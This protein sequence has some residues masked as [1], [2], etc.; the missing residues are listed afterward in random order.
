MIIGG[1][2][3]GLN[4]AETLRQSGYTGQIT[5]I[6]REASIPYDR[7]LITKALAVGDS[8]KWSL[9]P[10]EYLKNA[11]IEY[12]LKSSAFNI[13]TEKSEVVL[14][15][16]EHIHYDKLLIATGSTVVKPDIPGINSKGVHIVRTNLDQTNIKEAA[17]TSKKIV[18]IGAS[19]IGSESASC[20]AN[21]EREVHLIFS[22]EYPLEKVLG[23]EV[24]KLMKAEH[25]ANGVKLHSGVRA[26]GINSNSDG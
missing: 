18:V 7:T 1:G 13:N 5:L 15:S 20:L 24:G 22:S 4:A 2:A 14:T 12:K 21:K 11:D 6:C 25:E 10:E 26:V 23:K 9:R 3:A 19:F 8:S 17:K 16:G